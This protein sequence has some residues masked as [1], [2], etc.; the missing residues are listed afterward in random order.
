MLTEEMNTRFAEET[1]GVV[2]KWMIQEKNNKGAEIIIHTLNHPAAEN[3][4]ADLLTAGYN[5]RY[6]P[7]L[8]LQ[9]QL[10][11]VEHN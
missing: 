2:V 6:V 9:T 7:Y 5:A 8:L 3:M 10:A 4:L 1:G 11:N